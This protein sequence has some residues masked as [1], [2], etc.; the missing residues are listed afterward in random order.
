M[1]R[2]I[3]LDVD[4]VLNSLTLHIL[5]HYGCDIGP[6]EYDQFPAEVGYDIISACELLGGRVPYVKGDQD[7]GES[8]YVYDIPSFWQGVT[9]A[10]LWRTVPKSPQCDFLINRASEL[11]GR[12]EVYLATTPTK[13][14][15]SYGHKV[16]WILDNLPEWIHR[17]HAITPRK[18]ITGK[19]GVLLF[20]D[21]LENCHNFVNDLDGG[22]EALLVPRPWNPSHSKDTD[23]VITVRFDEL[24]WER[25]NV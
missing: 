18:W 16:H 7:V 6:F 19:P 17:Q 11:V 25:A 4:D 2:R 5:R 21:H 9:A 13:D 10:D 22:G 24:A 20:D 15:E 23:T 14:P 1:I 3:I 8:E 12:D